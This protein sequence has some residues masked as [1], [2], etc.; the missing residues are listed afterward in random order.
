MTGL[1]GINMNMKSRKF[2]GML[3][4]VININLLLI[5]AFIFVQTAVNA[6]VLTLAIFM[7]G[8]LICAYIGGN[9]YKSFIKS[10]YFHAEL[11]EEEKEN[12]K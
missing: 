3:I 2:I 10:K 9:V 12:E 11:V 1:E 7:I 8:F 4:G 6:S 5:A